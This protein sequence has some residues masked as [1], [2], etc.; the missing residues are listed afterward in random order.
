[1]F[2]AVDFHAIDDKTKFFEDMFPLPVK[3]KA[4]ESPESKELSKKD[5]KLIK[6]QARNKSKSD[7]KSKAQLEVSPSKL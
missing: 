5:K 1:M 7:Q 3:R 2:D 6:T 4:T